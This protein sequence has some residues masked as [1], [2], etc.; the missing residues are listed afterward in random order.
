[1]LVSTS[2][3]LSFLGLES[4]KFFIN[5]NQ[6]KLILTID[7]TEYTVTL[8][9]G[10]YDSDSLCT[11]ISTKINA[12]N[13]TFNSSVEFSDSRLNIY[14][15]D[16]GSNPLSIEYTHSGS[17]AGYLLG[18]TQDQSSISGS[19]EDGIT[20][21]SA[22]ENNTDIVEDIVNFVDGY[23]KDVYCHNQIESADYDEYYELDG[24]LL[25]VD[26]Y[27]INSISNIAVG[28]INVFRVRYTNAYIM[29]NI[30][31]YNGKL[32]LNYASS[33]TILTL[34]DYDTIAELITAINNVSG[35]EAESVYDDYVNNMPPTELPET[36]TYSASDFWVNISV[37]NNDSYYYEVSRSTGIIEFEQRI[38]DN[39]YIEYNAGLSS[40]PEDLKTAVKLIIKIVYDKIKEGSLGIEY[41]K[42]DKVSFNYAKDIPQYIKD[43]LN[44]YKRILI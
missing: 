42:R 27:P 13:D 17:T 11:H 1:M 19:L 24:R 41:L 5:G 2:E 29:S 23:V 33:Q 7:G 12:L 3:A 43:V 35:W 39:V 18:F 6:N 15:E 16:D 9:N 44:K 38:N 25:N 4:L 20:A 40:I 22:P 26:N 36:G 8:D 10:F 14:V 32:Y 28:R 21:D 37:K 31:I 34:S 30:G